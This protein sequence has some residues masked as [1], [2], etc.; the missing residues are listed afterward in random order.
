VDEQ[1][2]QKQNRILLAEIKPDPLR[3][4]KFQS[5][6]KLYPCFS[7]YSGFRYKIP[8]GRNPVLQATYEFRTKAVYLAVFAQVGE[9]STQ[10]GEPVKGILQFYI[11]PQHLG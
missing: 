9:G 1:H 8:K 6:P 3:I 5:A 10:G 4:L 7:T 2:H 11:H